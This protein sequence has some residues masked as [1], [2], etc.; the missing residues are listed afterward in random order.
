VTPLGERP[1]PPQVGG[2]A[3]PVG[4]IAITKDS[5]KSMVQRLA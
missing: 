1:R 2:D 5:D 3:E 4:A